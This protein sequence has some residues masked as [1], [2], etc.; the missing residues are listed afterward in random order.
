MMET[1][2]FSLGSKATFNKALRHFYAVND[3][4]DEI[5]SKKNIADYIND[6][7]DDEDLH[8]DQI[9]PIIGAVLKDK[10][11]YII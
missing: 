4:V 6:L 1:T 2:Y 9:L 11:G 7:L 3:A 8:F 10:F 5:E